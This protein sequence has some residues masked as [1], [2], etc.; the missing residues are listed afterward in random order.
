MTT[1]PMSK[2]KRHV[3]A[4]GLCS[5]CGRRIPSFAFYLKVG[6]IQRMNESVTD[7][8]VARRMEEQDL[9]SCAERDIVEEV[10]DSDS[11]L[12][13]RPVSISRTIL[14]NLDDYDRW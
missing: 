6:E 1:S 8:V 12:M 4:Q 3:L 13:M 5:H 2:P 11:S 7:L 9:C 14:P 10:H